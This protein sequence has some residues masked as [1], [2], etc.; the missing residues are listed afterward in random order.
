MVNAPYK[1]R[2]VLR[3]GLNSAFLSRTGLDINHQ[4][5]EIK[6]ASRRMPRKERI[7]SNHK[8]FI[9]NLVLKSHHEL[10]TS[11]LHYS[12]NSANR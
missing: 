5:R 2:Y 4:V 7:N 12:Y 9:S 10:Q 1:F 6:K 11:L 8:Q 3:R